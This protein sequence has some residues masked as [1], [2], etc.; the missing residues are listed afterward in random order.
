[1]SRRPYFHVKPYAVIED[2][3]ADK[4]D[5]SV[6]E[7]LEARFVC[8]AKCLFFFS[9]RRRHTRWNCD[10]NSDVCSSD[11]PLIYAGETIGELQAA[12]R[13]PQEPFNDADNRMLRQLA[14]QISVAAHAVQLA[15]DLQR[16]RLRK[17]GRASCR[18]RVKI[19]GGA[20]S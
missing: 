18:E 8:D 5:D 12:Y 20:V 1:M 19:S 15:A 16:A 13:S 9:S 3:Q 2:C 7:G 10:W 17:I 4:D 11:L 6:D 14:Q